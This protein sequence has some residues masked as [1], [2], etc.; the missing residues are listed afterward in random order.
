MCSTSPQAE[1]FCLAH[2]A[3]A[4]AGATVSESRSALPTGVT[5]AGVAIADITIGVTIARAVSTGTATADIA[6]AR[7][8]SA[9]IQT[10]RTHAPRL[11]RT[12]TAP[13]A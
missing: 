11:T 10:L 6:I 5:I 1:H 8:V 9:Y 13:H 12:P 3:T 7:A 2:A 4:A